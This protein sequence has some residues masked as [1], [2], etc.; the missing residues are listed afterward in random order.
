MELQDLNKLKTVTVTN[1]MK[2]Q[3]DENQLICI[4]CLEEYKEN[5]KIKYNQLI[6][7]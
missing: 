5:E 2:K 4:V 6:Y 3:F 1:L 7:F